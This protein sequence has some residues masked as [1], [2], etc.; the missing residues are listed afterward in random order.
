V[1]RVDTQAHRIILSA[2]AWL[3]DQNRETQDAFQTRFKPNPSA[4]AT[5]SV[6][7]PAAEAIEGEA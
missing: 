4:E 3:A 1:T 6:P 2:R 5:E 7:E